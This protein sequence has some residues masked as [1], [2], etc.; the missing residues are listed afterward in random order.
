MNLGEILYTVILYPLVQIIEIAFMLFDKLFDN[1]G[2]AV[3][4]VSFVVT[5]PAPVH[6][7]GAM[8]AAGA[9][10]SG[11]AERWGRPN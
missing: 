10:Y 8:A 3:M 6:R 11:S 4:G 5:V 7:G 2:I 9:G 1:T